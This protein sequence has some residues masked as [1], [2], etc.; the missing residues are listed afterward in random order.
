VP[1]DATVMP[2]PTELTTPPVTKIYFGI[3][4]N[5]LKP[6]V[7]PVFSWNFNLGITTGLANTVPLVNSIFNYKIG[8]HCQIRWGFLFIIRTGIL[9]VKPPSLFI[10]SCQ[11]L[12]Y[13]WYQYV[14]VRGC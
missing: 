7:F 2:F 11:E 13:P 1:I 14:E 4:K 3:P 5:Y 6:G 12:F 10:H 9:F 8:I